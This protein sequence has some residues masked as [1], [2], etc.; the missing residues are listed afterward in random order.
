MSAPVMNA[1]AARTLVD[2]GFFSRLSHRVATAH[3]L[4][5]TEAEEITDQALAY[6]AASAQKTAGA[7]VLSPSPAVDLGVHAFLEYTEAYDGFFASRGWEKVHHHPFDDP[8]RVYETASVVLPRT[9][10][11]IRA[12]GYTVLP[13]L[14]DA[15]RVDC[16]DDSDGKG[17]NPLPCGDHG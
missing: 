9:V 2:P 14:W 4:G 17:G 7:G 15:A 6:L 1:V 16:S 8:A 10:D 5:Q 3:Q 13:E 12:C 11:A